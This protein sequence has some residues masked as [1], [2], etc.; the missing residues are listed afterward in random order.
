MVAKGSEA[1]SLVVDVVKV[2]WN[3][4][5][6]K[7]RQDRLIVLWRHR[8]PGEGGGH[9]RG[10]WGGVSGQ[11]VV[12]GGGVGADP[13][14]LVGEQEAY[15]EEY[16]L[17]QPTDVLCEQQ[18][19]AANLLD[20][21]VASGEQEVYGEEYK[22]LN[23]PA[24]ASSVGQGAERRFNDKSGQVLKGEESASHEELVPTGWNKTTA[25]IISLQEATV[26]EEV[27]PIER[28]KAATRHQPG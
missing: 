2:Q 28:G 1:G 4:P 19:R 3:H 16:E 15:G 22:F 14:S 21:V 10:P 18:F 12:H 27:K 11:V 13:A 7:E 26:L 5:V 20:G 24:S 25:G 9:Q 6:L 17:S 23:N 8:P